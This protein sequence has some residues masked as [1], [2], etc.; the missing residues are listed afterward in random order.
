MTNPIVLLL[1]Y[2]V[3]VAVLVAIPVC[4]SFRA[5]NRRHELERWNAPR[6]GE[7]L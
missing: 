4:L 5:A 3:L 1:G 2:W 7:G 6:E